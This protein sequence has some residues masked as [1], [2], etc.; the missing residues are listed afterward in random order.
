MERIAY[1]GPVDSP[2][3]LVDN[4]QAIAAMIPISSAD[5]KACLDAVHAVGEGSASL[6]GF[7]HGGAARLPRL[8]ASDLTHVSVCDLDSGKRAVVSDVPGAIAKR[9]LDAFNRHFNDHPIVRY[10]GRNPRARTVRIADLVAERDWRRSPLYDEYYRAVGIDH[11]MVL[12]VHVE[13][14]ELVSF[15]FNR[16]DR[17]FSDRDRACA[18]AIRPLLGDLYRVTRALDGARAAWG[19]PA[20]PVRAPA[21]PLTAR[22]LE[23]LQWLGSGK[24]D[25][26]IA[27]ILG[28]SPRTVHKHLQRI[29]QKLGVETRTAAV[30]RALAP[31]A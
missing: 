27:A 2:Y 29:Y 28:I 23:V 5:L 31:S 19:V 1:T 11:V 12:P 17:D 9:D 3:P 24:T 30:M 26:D 14:K 18:E 10:H 4:L 20:A 13:G 21:Q 8:I 22:E 16:H 15:V 25:K 6:E 7:M